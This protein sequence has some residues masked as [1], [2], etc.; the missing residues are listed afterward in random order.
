MKKKIFLGY[1]I[2]I[3]ATFVVPVVLTAFCTAELNT[4]AENEEMNEEESKALLSI[5]V[6]SQQTG[7]TTNEN[8]EEY[9]VGVVAA[10]MPASFELEALKA[11]AVAA[12]SYII[13]KLDKEN[14]AHPDA[15]VCDD[16]A[17]CKAYL[18]LDGAKEKWGK[19]WESDFYSKIKAAVDETSGEYLSYD[20]R[21]VQAF[22]FALSNGKTESAED[23]WGSEL[24][25]IKSTESN[26][27]IASPDFNSVKEISISDFNNGLKSFL[28]E[29][30]PSDKVQIGAIN[31]TKGGRVKDIKI[32]GKVFKGT[33]IRNIFSLNSADFSIKQENDK[34]I[35]NVKGK[36]H[37]VG[38]SQFG[39]NELAKQGYNY[40]EILEYYYNDIEISNM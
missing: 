38:M 39:A 26:F 8:M 21:A 9:L 37:G 30:K 20:K 24:P 25:Y 22:F 32:N 5:P 10:E 12:R 16:P 34:V 35:F 3:I 23:V 11:Q 17:H 31:Y 28:N 14:D 1:L 2:I 18:S 13:S 7:K 19:K 29:Y 15:V 6:F 40:K 4:F 36:G 27:D 33:D